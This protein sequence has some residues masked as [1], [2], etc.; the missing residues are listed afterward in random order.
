MDEDARKTRLQRRLRRQT[1]VVNCCKRFVAFLFLHVGLA[2]MVVSYSILGGFLFMTLE[3][4]Y[5]LEL[6]TIIDQKRRDLKNNT[7]V[8][9]SK[10]IIVPPL[11]GG[12]HNRIDAA[13][14]NA[15][16]AENRTRAI[17]DSFEQGLLDILA[18]KRN[19]WKSSDTAVH[20]SDDDEQ[21]SF[22][23]SLLFAVTVITTIG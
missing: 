13:D 21:W 19:G 7:L 5:E 2:A 23:G 18:L 12:L 1:K 15:S 4:S 10:L 14:A 22:A 17:L 9:L 8:E 3:S 16:V 11:Q 20:G 6:K